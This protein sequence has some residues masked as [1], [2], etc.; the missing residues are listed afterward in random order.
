MSEHYIPSVLARHGPRAARVAKLL[1]AVEVAARLLYAVLYPVAV[2]L[3]P[4]GI[5]QDITL[6][7]LSYLLVTGPLGGL[8]TTLLAAPLLPFRWFGA[9]IWTFRAFYL[10][11]LMTPLAYLL[12]VAVVWR[13]TR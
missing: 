12:A 9:S 6:S 8:F 1:V 2:W 5:G 10:P 11:F 4:S 13:A 7:L 3:A